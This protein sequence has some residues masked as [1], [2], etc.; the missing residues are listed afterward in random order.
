MNNDT[1]TIIRSRY[2]SLS[3]SERK[4]A[5]YVLK[6]EED[7][8]RLTLAE[9]AKLSKVS[10]ATALRLCRTLGYEG[11]LD[12]KLALTR[13]MPYSR[14]MILGDLDQGDKPFITA[15]KVFQ[16]S[17]QALDDTSAV[18]I[19]EQ[20]NQALEMIKHAEHILIV[21]VGTSG[22]MGHEL[23]NRL[24]RV[25]L[26]CRA[27]TDSYLIVMQS[28]ML[29]KNDLLIAISQ[30]GRSNGPIS[31]AHE[32]RNHGCPVMCITGNPTSPLAALSDLVLLSVSH[33]SRPETLTSRIAQY[34]LIH[35]LYVSLAMQMSE[36]T[37]ETE[38][39]IW[40]ALMRHD[41]TSGR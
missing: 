10:D 18:L 4:V 32:A 35:A 36:T 37:L 34:A 38:N 11:W 5:D 3:N 16:I 40:G 23:F 15:K 6:N 29:K 12:F 33:E 7:V 21:G 30:G 41:Y 19:E 13:S 39:K 2:N 28:V 25:G 22:P 24:F 27:E 31:A 1:K 26:N 14:E 8:I 20:V 9:V 17:K